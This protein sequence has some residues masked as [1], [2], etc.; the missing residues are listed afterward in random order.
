MTTDLREEVAPEQREGWSIEDASAL[1]MIDRWGAGYFDVNRNGDLTVSP[2]QEKAI[3]IPIID[4]LREAQALNL[5]T[6]ILIRFQDLLRHRVEAL[7]NAF[8]RAIADNNYLGAYRGVFPIKVN[9]LREVVE[10][11]LD[12]GR[13]FN[14][15]LEVGSKPE[16][17]AGLAV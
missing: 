13:P 2:L 5:A 11:I 9:Q 12:A 8:N 1:Y 3:A 10:E 6:P 15:G 7:N 16:I 14:Y 17:Y 4:A